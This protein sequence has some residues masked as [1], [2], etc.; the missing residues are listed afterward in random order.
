MVAFVSDAPNLVNGDGNGTFD[1]FVA[2]VAGGG[3][4]VSRITPAAGEAN[5]PSYM[6]AISPDGHTVVWGSRANNLVD[7][8]GNNAYDWFARS[9]ADVACVTCNVAGVDPNAGNFDIGNGTGDLVVGSGPGYRFVAADGGIFS[10]GD[11]KFFGSMGG[12]PLNKPIV[13]MAATRSGKGYWLV[14]SDGGIFSF[15]D[16][17]FLGSMGGTPLNKPIVGMAK[18]RAGDGYWLVATDG[19][20]FSFGSAQFFG[21]TGDIRL[22]SPIVGMAS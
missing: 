13:G 3:V 16:A 10:F 14:A 11:A 19:G 18:A 17:S 7:G 9:D 1:L 8:D 20:I 6:P 15:G 22:N 12:K 5:G 4:T 2:K 21:S